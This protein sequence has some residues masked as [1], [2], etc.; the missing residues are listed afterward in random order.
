VNADRLARSDDPRDNAAKVRALLTGGVWRAAADLFRTCLA[1]P[2][3]QRAR[4]C[5][6]RIEW[7]D[8]GPYD[9][10]VIDP[11]EADRVGY[12]ARAIGDEW[13]LWSDNEYDGS[14]LVGWTSSLALGVE[15]LVSGVHAAT[16][17]H[18]SRRLSG[19][20]FRPFR[21]DPADPWGD[22][23]RPAADP[24]AD[25]LNAT[26]RPVTATTNREEP[27]VTTLNLAPVLPAGPD[28]IWR[29]LAGPFTCTGCG[30]G[31]ILD[32]DAVQ[33]ADGS[34]KLC[35]TCNHARLD[36][37]WDAQPAGLYAVAVNGETAG[38][39]RHT[40]VALHAYVRPQWDAARRCAECERPESARVHR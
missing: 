39:V 17:R 26:G 32:N 31:V 37:F 8:S 29:G 4:V 12:A 18:D 13:V 10:A 24:W 5:V 16:G 3:G 36:D 33:N 14:R 40:P 23:Q 25:V 22:R 35:R 30:K 7:I 19:G 9:F 6:G 27:T 21:I 15:I 2:S 28:N 34:R 11:R 38:Y 20:T 1:G